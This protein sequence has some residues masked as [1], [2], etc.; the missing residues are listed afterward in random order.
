[1][2]IGLA[3][4]GLHASEDDL[5]HELLRVAARHQ[6]DQELFHT[7]RLLARWS[8][9]HVRAVAAIAHR[10]GQE[11]DPEPR[12]RADGARRLLEQGSELVGRMRSGELLVLR[13]LRE[14]AMKAYGV[15]TEWEMVA[16]AAQGARDPDL[17]AVC[18][19]CHPQTLR[20]LRWAN[21][22]IKVL[23]TQALLA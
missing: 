18:Q 7:G 21:A 8:Q 12:D 14:T 9:D 2:K 16:Q 4:R 17:L 20:Q 19:Q 10:Y 5:A 15:S 11:L 22:Q 23:S 6:A 3:L 1:M 13:D